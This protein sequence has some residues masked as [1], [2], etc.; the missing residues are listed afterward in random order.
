MKNTQTDITSYENAWLGL[1]EEDSKNFDKPLSNLSDYDKS[2]L[3]LY[4]LKKMRDPEYFHWT[5]K[6]LFNVDLLYIKRAMEKTIPHVYSLSG[7]W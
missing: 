7:F 5:V 2:N 6:T 4:I 3:H 1:T